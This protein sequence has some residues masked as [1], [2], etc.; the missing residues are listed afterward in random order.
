MMVEAGEQ[1]KSSALPVDEE[2]ELLLL[3]LLVHPSR[4]HH[5]QP[6]LSANGGR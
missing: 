5:I 2:E 4:L 6:S 1:R 3:L